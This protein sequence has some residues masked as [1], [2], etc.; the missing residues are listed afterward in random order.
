MKETA[1][2]AWGRDGTA[3]GAGG[4]GTGRSCAGTDGSCAGGTPAAGSTGIAAGSP[5]VTAAGGTAMEAGA[6]AGDFPAFV[7]S[8][9]TDAPSTIAGERVPAFP[10]NDGNGTSSRRN[11]AAAVAFLKTH[12]SKKPPRI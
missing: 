2:T 5:D 10:P 4:A 8:G 3:A 12:P 9:W 11:P 6:E 7:P 1:G